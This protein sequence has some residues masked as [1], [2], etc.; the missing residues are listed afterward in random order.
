MFLKQ[1]YHKIRMVLRLYEMNNFPKALDFFNIALGFDDTK[2]SAEGWI[3]YLE[4]LSKQ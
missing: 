3:N 1:I 4:E 2:I